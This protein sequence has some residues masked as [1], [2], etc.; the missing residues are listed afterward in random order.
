MDL[1]CS[2][3]VVH[4]LHQ[5]HNLFSFRQFLVMVRQLKRHKGYR[6]YKQMLI[7][8]RYIVLQNLRLQ[9]LPDQGI[10]IVNVYRVF[11][12]SDVRIVNLAHR[13]EDSHQLGFTYQ[14]WEDFKVPTELTEPLKVQS[15]V[16]RVRV[17]QEVREYSFM[18]TVKNTDHFLAL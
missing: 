10:D 11:V 7:D 8:D 9:R 17:E 18:D 16:E 3:R 13:H 12:H 1:V 2:L 15:L 14:F 6:F 5:Q 4:L